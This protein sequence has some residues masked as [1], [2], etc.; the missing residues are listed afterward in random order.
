VS[1]RR[2]WSRTIRKIRRNIADYGLMRSLAKILAALCSIVYEH[3]VYRVYVRDL[4]R[5]R[6]PSPPD[7]PSSIVFKMLD[8]Q[9]LDHPALGKIEEMEEWLDGQVKRKLAEGGICLVALSGAEVAGFN[10]V[11]FSSVD[12]PLVRQTR[13]LGDKEA[14]SEQITVNRRHR[15]HGLGTALRYRMLLEL[16]RRG[17]RRFYGGALLSNA[18]SLALSRKLGFREVEDLHYRRLFGVAS[19]YSVRLQ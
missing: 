1:N 6:L 10:L 12:I 11:A 8:H 5:K 9:H 17:I 16:R 7:L 3:T 18:A 19:S 4:G 14:W 13:K 2:G 15:R